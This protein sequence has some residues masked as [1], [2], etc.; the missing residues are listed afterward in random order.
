ME[1]LSEPEKNALLASKYVAKVTGSQVSFTSSFK[2]KAVEMNL[3][4]KSPS[5]IFL[6][7]GI[8]VALFLPGYP[9]KCITRWKKIFL[10]EGKEGLQ[11]DKRGKKAKGRPK[12]K[13]DPDDINSVMARLAY[14]EAENDFLKKLHAL[15]D[16]KEKKGTR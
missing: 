13:Y 3:E 5:E 12:K 14:L 9:K 8:D 10:K 7:L 1:K 6:F 11:E 16:L 2:I 4:G 15:A